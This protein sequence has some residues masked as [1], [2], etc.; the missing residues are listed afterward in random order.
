MDEEDAYQRLAS[1]VIYTIPWQEK[2]ER[3]ILVNRP[4]QPYLRIKILNGDNP[5]LRI[6][7]VDVSW[8]RHNL[9]F[10]P[11]TGRHYRL[12]F[13]GE[14]MAVPEYELG[15][16]VR[17]DYATLQAYP[18][19]SVGQVE[20]NTDYDPSL[21][22]DTKAQIEKIVFSTL[23]LLVACGLGWWGYQL[24]KKIPARPVE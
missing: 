5:P 3:V 8:V 1:G 17:A 20:A 13:G 19:W 23:V 22:P 4:Q 24:L 12:Y 10:I 6:A 7:Q 2:P 21:T 15:K 9:Y 18:A 14:Q 16:L 11:E